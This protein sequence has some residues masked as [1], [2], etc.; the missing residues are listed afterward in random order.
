MT[1]SATT[2]EL[3]PTAAEF[4]LDLVPGD[5]TYANRSQNVVGAVGS[6][7]FDKLPWNTDLYDIVL[8]IENKNQP[9]PELTTGQ[10]GVWICNCP[11]YN[12][13]PFTCFYAQ[14]PAPSPSNNCVGGANP[15]DYGEYTSGGDDET[16]NYGPVG[17]KLQKLIKENTCITDPKSNL[18][19][20]RTPNFFVTVFDV[21]NGPWWQSRGG[22]VFA[23]N[24]LVSHIPTLS[25]VHNSNVSNS[26]D[27]NRCTPPHCAPYLIAQT[28]NSAIISNQQKSAAYPLAGSNTAIDISQL[29]TAGGAASA[30]TNNKTAR[31]I[32]NTS[33]Q[34]V[35]YGPKE[36]YT[37]FRN[38]LPGAG[39]GIAGQISSTAQLAGCRGT[40]AVGGNN[41]TTIFC[42][43]GG[44]LTITDG[45]VINVATGESYTVFVGGNL[46]IGE[47]NSNFGNS[48]ANDISPKITVAQGGYLS[49]IVKQDIHIAPQVGY[50]NKN[51]HY[52]NSSGQLLLVGDSSFPDFGADTTQSCESGDYQQNGIIQGVFLA[53]GSI[54]VQSNVMSSIPTR[55]DWVG[56]KQCPIG[57]VPDKKFVGE[58]TFVGW[59]GIELQRD[60][61]DRCSFTKAWNSRQPTEVFNY[62]PDFLKN[63]PEWM[64]R[65]IRLRVESL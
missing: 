32:G 59:S 13:D 43:S 53:D 16:D 44:D 18:I 9:N 50:I 61:D 11:V 3:N 49:F 22:T 14:I 25:N 58:G 62:R 20:N 6:Y 45:A 35:H 30:N 8:T 38:L 36:D 63:A 56:S 15:Y 29:A 17:G 2:G 52:D 33:G 28:C 37:Y 12:F 5:T 27:Y 19:E 10:E 7:R 48:Y 40:F 57:V 47:R 60:F 34:P 26:S 24:T 65:S 54:V 31:A 46:Y 21:H 1:A 64:W 51:I 23:A 42:V 4:K 39:A 41:N 55:L